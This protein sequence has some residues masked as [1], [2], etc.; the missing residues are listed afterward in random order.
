MGAKAEIGWTR[1]TEE[2]VKL[3]IYVQHAGKKWLFFQRSKR[4][5]PWAA[6]EDPPLEDWLELLDAVRRMI[7]RRRYPQAAEAPL[8]KLIKEKFPEAEF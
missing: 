2:G 7:P 8:I 1:R 3:D 6:I 4:Y 5:E